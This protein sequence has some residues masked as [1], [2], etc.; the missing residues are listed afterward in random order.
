M[1]EGQV[2]DPVA[3]RIVSVGPRLDDAVPVGVDVTGARQRS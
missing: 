3:H 2:V 1:T